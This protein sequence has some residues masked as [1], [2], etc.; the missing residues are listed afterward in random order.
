MAGRI[1]WQVFVF[2]ENGFRRI[3]AGQSFFSLTG[4]PGDAAILRAGGGWNRP[5]H[6]D[7]PPL[8]G[9]VRREIFRGAA[10]GR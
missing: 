3:A 8:A 1:I 9:N 7:S 5:K 2:W 4:F 6:G 10:I